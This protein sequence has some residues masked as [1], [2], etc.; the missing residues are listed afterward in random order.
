MVGGTPTGGLEPTLDIRV[1]HPISAQEIKQCQELSL[2]LERSF[3]LAQ[4]RA[5]RLFVARVL[6][7][8]YLCSTLQQYSAFRTQEQLFDGRTRTSEPVVSGFRVSTA[9]P[10]AS[11]S[12][13]KDRRMAARRRSQTQL[14][15]VNTGRCSL[16]AAQAHAK[17]TAATACKFLICCPFETTA[18]REPPR[19]IP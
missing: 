6:R 19:R 18:I 16:L 17:T 9:R 7:T 5:S 15:G 4:S 12:V 3:L 11:Q 10:C 2:H 14:T 13:P 1:R 8:R